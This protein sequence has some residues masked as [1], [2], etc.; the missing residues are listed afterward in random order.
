MGFIDDDG[1]VTIKKSIIL[2]L[3][4]QDTVGHQFDQR[5]FR[6]LIGK[7]HLKAH[8]F[9]QWRR[10]LISNSAS[11]TPCRQTT[12]LCVTNQPARATAQL[13]TDLG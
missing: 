1:V 2:G 3:G 4:E 8:Q 5:L 7:A 13:Q 12:R 9:T 6:A 11:H 10:Q